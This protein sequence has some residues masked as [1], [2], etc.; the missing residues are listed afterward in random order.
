MVPHIC[1]L[2]MIV[3][4]DRK[5]QDVRGGVNQGG[6]QPMVSQ[7]VAASRKLFV[8]PMNTSTCF[9]RQFHEIRY[10]KKIKQV[11]LPSYILP[12]VAMSSVCSVHLTTIITAFSLLV[13]PDDYLQ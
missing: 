6:I 10:C 13:C 9:V 7:Q 1:L 12:E 3:T 4:V 2:A 5:G 8:F 11:N